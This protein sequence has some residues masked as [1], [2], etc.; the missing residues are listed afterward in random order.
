MFQAIRLALLTSAYVCIGVYA[1]TAVPILGAQAWAQSAVEED[2]EIIF[3]DDVAADTPEESTESTEPGEE[4][5]DSSGDSL[6]EEIE[7]SSAESSSEEAVDLVAAEQLSGK[8]DRVSWQD[9]VVVVRKPFLKQRRLE[10]SPTWGITMNDNLIRHLQFNAQVNYWLTDVLAVGLEGGVFLKE[11]RQPFDRIGWQARRL[12]GVNQYKWS[13]ALNFHYVPIYGKFA[14]LNKHIVHW[15]TLFTAGV[16]VTSTEVLQRDRQFEAFS[17]LAITPN[18]GASMRFFVTKWLTVNIGLRDYIFIDQYEATNR[19][20]RDAETAKANADPSL[21][22][23]V[24]FQA[25]VSIWLPF[26]FDYTT[27]R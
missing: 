19:T 4:P 20:E 24:V 15:E 16:G 2:E 3:E 1:T 12:P 7:G 25:G 23:H 18:V 26:S 14:I 11:L 17:N 10:L 27:F 6:L 22:N 8:K 5:V 13:A 9:I 21:V